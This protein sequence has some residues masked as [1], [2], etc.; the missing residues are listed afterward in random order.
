MTAFAYFRLPYKHHAT[1]MEQT[2]GEPLVLSSVSELN[3]KEGFVIAPFAVSEECPVLLMQ[4]DAVSVLGEREMG[5]CGSPLCRNVG[6]ASEK[7]ISA[8]SP[9]TSKEEY[10][11]N[12]ST[13]H[14]ALEKGFFQKIVLARC[15][16]G[17]LRDASLR[18]LF[19]RTCQRYPR[20]FVS[21]VHTEQSGTWLMAT[22]EVLLEGKDGTFSTMALAG[23]QQADPSQVVADS[24]VEGVTWSEK[25]CEEQQYVADYL[26][27]TLRE[28]TSD[29]TA[30]GPY[31]TMAANLYHLRTDFHFRL[32]DTRHLGDVLERLYPTPAVC[33][34]PKEEARQFILGHE[35]A[36][37]RYYSGFVGTVSPCGDT[38]LYVSLRCMH[39]HDSGSC[40]LYAGGGLLRESVLQ[41][42]W[43]ETEAKLNTMRNVL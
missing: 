41:T 21:L 4:P 26:H 1:L 11:S 20:L 24:P 43:E 19:F 15:A 39:V 31:T 14:T 30:K 16:H 33:G 3:G 2:Q 10:A 13:F 32:A 12:F 36:P 29:I 40:D 22:P 8:P 38:H 34:I 28:F 27:Q 42:E 23:T 6:T 37:R 7:D 25:N 5:S 18:K 35:H 17:R 9:L